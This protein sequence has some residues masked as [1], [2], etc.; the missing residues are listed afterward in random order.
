M[1]SV[2]ATT[3]ASVLGVFLPQ[4][5]RHPPEGTGSDYWNRSPRGCEDLRPVFLP[6]LVERDSDADLGEVLVEDVLLVRLGFHPLR[7]RFLPGRGVPGDVLAHLACLVSR[8]VDAVDERFL[9]ERVVQL[10]LLRHVLGMRSR[11]L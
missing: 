3:A 8:S 9:V 4:R 7:D 10:V 5:K 2:M 11:R 6:L 1:V